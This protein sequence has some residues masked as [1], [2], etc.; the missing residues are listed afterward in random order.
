MCSGN[1]KNILNISSKIE[2]IFFFFESLSQNV[3]CSVFPLESFSVYNTY[4]KRLYFLIH[5]KLTSSGYCFC[6]VILSGPFT[7]M[8]G[9]SSD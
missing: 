6:K 8:M 1:S 9:L 7:E 4:K 5:L 2:T 3:K